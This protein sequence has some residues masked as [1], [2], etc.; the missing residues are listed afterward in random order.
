MSIM[1][2]YRGTDNPIQLL[3]LQASRWLEQA[4]ELHPHFQSNFDRLSQRLD[5]ACGDLS[6]ESGHFTDLSVGN[7]IV[8]VL[9]EILAVMSDTAPYLS[10]VANQER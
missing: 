1:T 3:A 4:T 9:R 8:D 10:A 7:A 2:I 6:D 5:V